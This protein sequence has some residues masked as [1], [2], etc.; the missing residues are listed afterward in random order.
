MKVEFNKIGSER[1]ELVKAISEILKR[2]PK[3]M[4]MPSMAYDFGG[5]ILDKCGTLHFDD[6]IF[7]K[8]INNLLEE[9]SKRGFNEKVERP[10][11]EDESPQE[12]TASLTVAFPRDKLDLYHLNKILENK[13]DLIKEALKITSLEIEE[14]DEKISFVWLNE[15]HKENLS[16]YTKFIEKLCKLSLDVKRVNNS[17]K[18]AVNKKYSFRCFLLR[19]GFI[20]DEYKIDRK[21]LLK[22][23]TGSSAFR[24]G[25]HKD[26]ISK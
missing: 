4:G 18:D 9:L 5:A 3:Y 24:N 20:G 1:K 2:K 13:G 16:T 11:D 17:S 25:G 26:E 23:L 8:D 19:L 22:N 21:I 6:N 14:D 12:G 15:Y 10:N 7:L